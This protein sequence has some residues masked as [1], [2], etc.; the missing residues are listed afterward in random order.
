MDNTVESLS[1]P[2]LLL[3]W[4]LTLQA[5]LSTSSMIILG[6]CNQILTIMI[7]YTYAFIIAD[8]RIDQPLVL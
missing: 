7:M 1:L 6:Y 8:A 5:R 2:A 3:V 4:S